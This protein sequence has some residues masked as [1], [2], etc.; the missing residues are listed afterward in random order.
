VKPSGLSVGLLPLE[1]G[2]WSQSAVSRDDGSF[3]FALVGSER[4][5]VRIQGEVA[6]AFYIKGI[7]YGDTES[8]D[9]IISISGVEGSL[10]LTLSTNGARLVAR[11]SGVREKNPLTPQVVL[12]P[13]KPQGET[14]LGLFDQNG[15]FSFNNLAPGAYKLY[16]FQEVPEGSWE[17]PDFVKEIKQRSV[18]ILLSEGDVQSTEVPLLLKTDLAPILRKLGLE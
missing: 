8:S 7:R 3:D 4:Y 16:A 15:V 18:D 13:E 11:V 2:T 10:V 1:G 5:Q 9:G 12:I 17:D 6:H 14:R